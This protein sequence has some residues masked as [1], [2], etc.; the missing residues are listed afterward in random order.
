MPT[1]ARKTFSRLANG[2]RFFASQREMTLWLT[3][4][5]SLAAGQ[6]TGSAPEPQ[7]PTQEVVGREADWPGDHRR[8][9][10]NPER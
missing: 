6:T 9:D 1:P 3:L 8:A 2:Q 10:G 4:S 5:A 7:N